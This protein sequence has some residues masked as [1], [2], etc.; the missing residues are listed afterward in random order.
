M[1]DT[2]PARG[3]PA[4]LGVTKMRT[5]TL[6]GLIAALSASSSHANECQPV[7]EAATTYKQQLTTVFSLAK[8]TKLEQIFSDRTKSPNPLTIFLPT[9]AA[10]GKLPTAVTEAVTKSASLRERVLSDHAVAGRINYVQFLNAFELALPRIASNLTEQ[11]YL[12]AGFPQSLNKGD[13]FFGGAS[14][15]VGGTN[16]IARTEL[17]WGS[18]SSGFRGAFRDGSA[19]IVGVDY[20]SCAG[21]VHVIDTVITRRDEH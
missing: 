9:N 5:L 6:L 19:T 11:D 14:L 10:F 3:F 17:N 15:R 8:G 12:K 18:A 4:K 2:L 13:F 16:L 1:K 20:A 7:L 21:I